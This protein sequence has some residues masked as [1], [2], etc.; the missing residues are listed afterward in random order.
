MTG[1]VLGDPVLRIS[2]RQLSGPVRLAVV[3]ILAA[4]P[5]VVTAI[6]VGTGGGRGDGFVEGIISGMLAAAILPIVTM[7]L[8]TTAFGNELE[9]KTLGYL[10]LKPVSR[11]RIVAP[12]FAVIVLMAG[13]LLVLSGVVT[14]L[15]AFDA[16]ARAA[17]AVAVGI[18]VG[19]IAYA[20]VFM[21]LGLMTT[22]ALGFALL[23][24]FLWEGILATFLDGIRFLS[25]RS[26][27]MSI[28]YGIDDVKLAS[29]GGSAIGLPAAAVG[30]GI[31]TAIFFLLTVRRLRTMDVP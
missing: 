15:I 11:L 1:R 27:T 16:D 26:Y 17:A 25:I 4:I 7:A 21:W 5:I 9:D 24:V 30:A 18:A 10:V 8:A 12:K 6:I 14:A 19:S 29:L 3:V 2:L 28:M 22:R 23:Y 13:P 31:V 20:S